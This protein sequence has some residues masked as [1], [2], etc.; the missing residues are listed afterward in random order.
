M[1]ISKK[2][3]KIMISIFTSNFIHVKTNHNDIMYIYMYIY[4]YVILCP[5]K[6][7][8]AL[9]IIITYCSENGSMQTECTCARC[10]CQRIGRKLDINLIYSI[11]L[12]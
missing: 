12:I 9:S 8:P 7:Y 1:Y 11:S 2:K 4:I 5:S 6:I 10:R 3:K